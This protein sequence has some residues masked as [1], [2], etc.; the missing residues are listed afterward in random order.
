[1]NF[2][3]DLMSLSPPTGV[4]VVVVVVVVVAVVV[5]VV[6]GGGLS[7]PYTLFRQAP[8]HIWF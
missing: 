4:V 1:M 6:V 2:W 5:V 7:V 3:G 8:P